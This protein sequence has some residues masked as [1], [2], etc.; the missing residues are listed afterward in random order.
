VEDAP[1]PDILIVDRDTT[2]LRALERLFLEAGFSVTAVSDA[3]RARDQIANRFFGVLLLDLDTP[4]LLGGIDLL[5]F[6]RQASPL[7]AVVVM[8]PRRS[9][10]AVAS[11]FR[12]GANDVVPKTEQALPYLRTRVLAA[13]RDLKASL[14]RERLLEEV[15]EVHEGFLREMMALSRQVTDLED[16]ILRGEGEGSTT[17]IPA[18]LDLLVVDDEQSLRARLSQELNPERGWRLRFAHTS[19]EAL[20]GA[21]QVRPHVLVAKETLPD[22]PVTMLIKTMKASMPELV[23]LVF[24]PFAGKRPGEVKMVE[25]SKV[26]TLIPS[27]SEPGQLVTALQDVREAL[28]RK[29]R[30]RRY[31]V[32][33]RKQ[34][35]AFLKQYNM[36]KQKLIAKG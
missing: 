28:R 31:A 9:F 13:A 30:E 11:A 8:T 3:D 32:T 21:H 7:S 34:H 23:A 6:A 17:A 29:A 2:V 20:D 16:K 24:Q 14:D 26:V 15:A 18:V 33:F 4:T 36:L 35:A 19:G 10:D 27:F 25:A 5:V 12:A 22:L 1:A